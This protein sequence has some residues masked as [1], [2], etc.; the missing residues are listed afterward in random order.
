VCF[1]L[2]LA[3]AD[4]VRYIYTPPP[5]MHGH[6]PCPQAAAITSAPPLLISCSCTAPAWWLASSCNFHHQYSVLTSNTHEPSITPLQAEG[7]VK[8]RPAVFCSRR[9]DER[10][11]RSLIVNTPWRGRRAATRRA[12]RRARG[13]RRRTSSSSPTSRTTAPATGA[14][15]PPE[16]VRASFTAYDA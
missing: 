11:L 12:S 2:D 4:T 15:S 5:P 16:P 8:A 10:Q 7:N 1:R 9:S 3:A 13:R 14:P 6:P